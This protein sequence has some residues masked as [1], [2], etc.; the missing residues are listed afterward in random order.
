MRIKQTLGSLLL[1]GLTMF[2]TVRAD[3]LRISPD[4]LRLRTAV[5][6]LLTPSL[7][8]QLRDLAAGN[9]LP[10]NDGVTQ[11]DQM[12]DLAFADQDWDVSRKDLVRYY[13]LVARMEKSRDFSDEFARRRGVTE[14][15]RTLMQAYLADLNR[16]IARAV[17]VTNVPVD[18]GEQLDFPLTSAGWHETDTGE[19]YLTVLHNYPEVDTRLGRETLRGLRDV[20]GVDLELLE[21]Q[22]SDLDDAERL[23]LS[24]IHLVGQE[25]SLLRPRVTK[26]VRLP[27]AG[28]PFSF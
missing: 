20:V 25:L 18:T 11:T 17:F 27:R 13:F 21:G 5:S 3:D 7:R 16:A 4:D 26:L 28:L 23:F 1:V 22:L 19:K 8:L 6:G 9:P 14:E 2:G 12:L 15:G 24:E 10:M